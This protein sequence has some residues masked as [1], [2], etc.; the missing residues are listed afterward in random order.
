MATEPTEPDTF[1]AI[2]EAATILPDRAFEEDLEFVD[3]L[4]FLLERGRLLVHPL[5]EFATLLAFGLERG[6]ERPRRRW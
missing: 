6:R 2:A 1:E 4:V 3:S 5:L